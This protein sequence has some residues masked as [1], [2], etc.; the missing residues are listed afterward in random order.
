M[1][2]TDLLAFD[3]VMSAGAPAG[4]ASKYTLWG[5]LPNANFT[6]SPTVTVT[7]DGVKAIAGVASTVA[8]A[9]G[10]PP[11]PCTGADDELQADVAAMTASDPMFRMNL[12][13][14]VI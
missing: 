7:F 12:C 4:L 11:P 6:V 1:R 8:S 9:P 14:C 3:P 10:L 5:T 13:I 2:V